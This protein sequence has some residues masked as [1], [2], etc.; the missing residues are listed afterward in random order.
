MSPFQVV[1][2]LLGV[3]L[4]IIAGV[5][6]GVGVSKSHK[7]KSSSVAAVKQT[8]PDD[9]STFEKNSALV[10]SFYGIAYTPEG[11]Q[12]P[13]CGAKLGACISHLSK[14]DSDPHI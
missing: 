7:S 9:P 14:Y 1:G 2:S 8:N 4:L 13:D 5:A 12:L 6:V 10:N 3:F 11:V